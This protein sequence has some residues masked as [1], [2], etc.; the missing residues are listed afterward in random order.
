WE[1]AAKYAG[2]A[3]AKGIPKAAELF[4]QYDLKRLENASNPGQSEIPVKV[5]SPEDTLTPEERI[6]LV[7]TPSDP[8][9]VQTPPSTTPVVVSGIG[10]EAL[11]KARDALRLRH[12]VK[13]AIAQYQLAAESGEIAAQRELAELFYEGSFVDRDYHSAIKWF[14][15]AADAGDAASQ[16]YLGAMY[17]IGKGLAKDKREAA[18]WLR[19]AAAQGDALAQDQLKMVERLIPR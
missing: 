12:D 11:S 14:R 9:I 15:Q 19:L 7:N 5:P 2:K 6:G 3:A 4:K 17:F 18:K 10:K 1:L 8:H 16:R 13:G